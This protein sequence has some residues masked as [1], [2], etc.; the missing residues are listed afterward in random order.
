[1]K[2]WIDIKHWEFEKEHEKSLIDKMKPYQY[3]YQ[4]LYRKI[5]A[6]ILEEWVKQASDGKTQ[7]PE[8]FKN[9]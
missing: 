6:L 9:K 5:E 3:M 1:M 2:N 8:E 7:L 4:E